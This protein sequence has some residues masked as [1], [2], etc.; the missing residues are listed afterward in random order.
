[1]A[2]EPNVRHSVDIRN[3]EE[4]VK[5]RSNYTR[6]KGEL[7]AAQTKL[8][9]VEKALEVA[10]GEATAAKTKFDESKLKAENSELKGQLRSLSHRRVFDRLAKAR[11]AS[12]DSLD[13][14][15]QASGYKADKDDIDEATLGT[16]LDELKSK[17]GVARL[18]VAAESAEGSTP[19]SPAPGHGQGG[20]D[21]SS[22]GRFRVTSA[23]I[24]DDAWVYANQ[25]RYK[26][27]IRT[28][29]LEIVD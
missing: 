20:R 13:L 17:P 26:E 29:T 18:F 15:W 14:L 10:R 11:Q 28:G 5:L 25:T 2:D 7:A 8:N 4:Y 3:T 16:L 6:V 27:A 23:Q 21:T 24:A 19:F 9:E 22:N 1:M 12:E